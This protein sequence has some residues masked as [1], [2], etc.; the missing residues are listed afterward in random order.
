M[1]TNQTVSKSTSQFEFMKYAGRIYNVYDLYKKIYKNE[2]LQN[3]D[4]M[5]SSSF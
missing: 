5:S 1:K 2:E 3:L 4:K